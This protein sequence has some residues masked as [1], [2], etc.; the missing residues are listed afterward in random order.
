[1][2]INKRGTETQ[3]EKTANTCQ[4]AY[5]TELQLLW[6]QPSIS[7]DAQAIGKKSV[8]C[9]KVNNSLERSA[10]V[11]EI[12]LSYDLEQAGRPTP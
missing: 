2:K 9:G 11:G 10:E 12:E 5:K 3:S 7:D 8:E 6:F 1:M 4:N